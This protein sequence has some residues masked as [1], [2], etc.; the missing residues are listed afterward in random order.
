VTR[1]RPH[2]QATSD[3]QPTVS[4]RIDAIWSNR[5][6]RRAWLVC[7]ASATL[8]LTLHFITHP[9]MLDLSVYRNEGLALRHGLALYGPIGA[10]YG[11]QA[12]YPPFAALCFT[13]LTLIPLGLCLALVAAANLILLGLA[14]EFSRRLVARRLGELNALGLP[15]VLA[16]GIWFEPVYATLHFGQINLLILVLIL[17]EFTRPP[18]ARSRGVALGLATALKITPALFIVYL[19]LTKRLRFAATALVTFG[20][21]TL[22]SFAVRPHE[23]VRFWTSLVFD[24]TRVG[25]M[26][27]PSNQSVRG[28][29][30]RAAHRFDL[31]ALGVVAIAITAVVGL[32][33]SV[34]AYRRRGEAWGLCAAA[35]T[36]LLVSP[37]SWSHHWVWCVP[38]AVLFLASG[39]RATTRVRYGLTAAFLVFFSY[40]VSVYPSDPTRNLHMSVGAQLIS[41]PYFLFGVLF[42]ALAVGR[43]G[44]YRPPVS[45]T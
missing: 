40:L 37:I 15:L 4:G 35:V 11:L 21:A 39:R 20:G 45:T 3:T 6:L 1:A 9:S 44:P 30:V 27:N 33:C 38:I 17:W 25:N 23:T 8:W 18:H 36:G 32:A 26:A 16:A 7:A 43:W 22:L 5:R 41:M 34:A 31:G 12:T 14:V 28:V 24:T 2:P 13:T 42:L 19:L 10:Q 29:L